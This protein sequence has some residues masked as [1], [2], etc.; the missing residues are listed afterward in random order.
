MRTK[1][2][3]Q[4]N[5]LMVAKPMSRSEFSLDFGN[6]VRPCAALG[7]KDPIWRLGALVSL[8]H[9]IGKVIL[10]QKPDRSL[11]LRAFQAACDRREYVSK[12]GI[13]SARSAASWHHSRSLQPELIDPPWGLKTTAT[14]DRPVGLTTGPNNTLSRP[15][16]SLLGKKKQP[17]EAPAQHKSKPLKCNRIHQNA[18]VCT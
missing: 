9:S 14:A 13:R 12:T 16:A 2:G 11:S 8:L 4:D 3:R 10:V 17:A 6:G 5:W 18:R 15:T 7:L 1:L